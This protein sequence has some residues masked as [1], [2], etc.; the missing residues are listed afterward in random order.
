MASVTA[1]GGRQRRRHE[2]FLDASAT[3]K[4][5]VALLTSL[6]SCTPPGAPSGYRATCFRW[7]CA[8]RVAA[9]FYDA[10]V[11]PKSHRPIMRL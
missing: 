5:R 8:V 4:S 9:R 7:D 2:V 11:A 1:E 6:A 3:A 10:V